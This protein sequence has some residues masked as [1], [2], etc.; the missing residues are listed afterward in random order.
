MKILTAISRS[1]RR[2]TLILLVLG[3]SLLPQQSVAADLELLCP[4]AI[5]SNGP[6]SMT[7][8]AGVRNID[9][10]GTS[11]SLR[12]RVVS[13]AS[14]SFS[15]SSFNDVGTFELSGILPGGSQ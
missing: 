5:D 10:G 12:F 15:D 4:C 6:T 2:P 14:P 9:A 13:H 8:T 1:L 7:I 11:G 3:M